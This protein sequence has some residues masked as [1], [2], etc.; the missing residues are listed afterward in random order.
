[1]K[2][3]EGLQSSEAI[4]AESEQGKDRKKEGRVGRERR[5]QAGWELGRERERERREEEKGR[6][7]VKRGVRGAFR[8]L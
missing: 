5:W 7:K 4:G 2:G 3:R 8:R 6:G 1:M